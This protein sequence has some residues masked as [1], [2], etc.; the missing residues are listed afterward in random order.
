MIII[1]IVSYSIFVSQNIL[2]AP[3]SALR[4]GGGNPSPQLQS[5]CDSGFATVQPFSFKH[6]PLLKS[7]SA[8]ETRLVFFRLNMVKWYML[9]CWPVQTWKVLQIQLL[10]II[11]ANYYVHY[12]SIQ[13]LLVNILCNGNHGVWYTCSK[14]L[15]YHITTLYSNTFVTIATNTSCSF[16]S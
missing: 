3:A 14:Y 15:N 13:L 4:V 2:I 16:Y 8:P 9:K 12:I 5:N 10:M 6:P 11:K 7:G 1:I